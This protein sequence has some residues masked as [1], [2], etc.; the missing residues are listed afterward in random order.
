MIKSVIVTLVAVAALAAAPLATASAAPA[1]KPPPNPCKTFTTK[2]ADALFGLKKGT[3]VSRKLSHTGSG[4]SELRTCT[5]KHGGN[6][7]TVNTS[8]VAGGFGGPLKCYNRPKLGKH[9]E[10]CV[11]TETNFKVSLS[12][13]E[14]HKVWFGDLDNKILKDKGAKLYAFSLAQSRAFKG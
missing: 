13:Y 5:V 9:G 6:K 2:S 8:Y 4:H 12:R 3:A 14:K 1:V 11:S 10:V 7:L